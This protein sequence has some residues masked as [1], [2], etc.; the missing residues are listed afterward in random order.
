VLL[1]D[2]HL[3]EARPEW[4]H[5]AAHEVEGRADQRFELGIGLVGVGEEAG[6]HLQQRLVGEV[7]A[8][9]DGAGGRV[10]QQRLRATTS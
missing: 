6:Q 8:L 2:R 4:P 3:D 1:A 10:G 7:E 5:H 9:A